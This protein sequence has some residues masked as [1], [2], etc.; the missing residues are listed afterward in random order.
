MPDENKP[1]LKV[2]EIQLVLNGERYGKFREFL[3]KKVVVKG[4]LWQGYSVH[5]KTAVLM[6]VED[7]ERVD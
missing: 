7:M 5:H 6:E 3:I 1:Q 4:A 2:R